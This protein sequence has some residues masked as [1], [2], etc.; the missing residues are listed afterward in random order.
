[1]KISLTAAV[2]LFLF[3]AVCASAMAQAPPLVDGDCGEY[4]GLKAKT[5]A[6][7]EDV[8]LSVYQDK[9]FVWF[10]YGYPDGS[11]AMADLKLKTKTFPAGINLHVSAQLGEWP[12]DKPDLAPKNAE[13][14]LWWNHKQ[15]TA[16][17][18]WINGMDRT[19]DTPRYK[20]KNARAREIQIAK[21]RFGRGVWQFSIEI[22]SIKGKDGKMY[23][24]TFPKDGTTHELKVS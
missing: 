4:V 3:L 10:C 1:M 16:N 8:Q 13:S 11:F 24:A 22:R 20:F 21:S 7:S 17:N 14:E 5:F 2:V 6:V 15:W 12:L 19:G 18:V 9:H 23:N